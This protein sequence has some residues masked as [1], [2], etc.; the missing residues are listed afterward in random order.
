MANQGFVRDLNLSEVTDGAQL[1]QNLAGGTVDADLRLFAGLSKQKSELFWNSLKN[2]ASIEQSGASLQD[3]IQFQWDTNYTYTDDDYVF[4]VPMNLLQDIATTYIGFA[5]SAPVLNNTVGPEI[6]YDRGENFTPGTYNNVSLTGGNGSGARANIIVDSAGQVESVEITND[7]LVNYQS[8]GIGY[9]AGDILEAP[10]LPGGSGFAL[11]VDTNPWKIALIGNYAWNTDQIS[12]DKLRVQISNTS[13]VLNGLYEVDQVS[14]NNTFA[15]P[16]ESTEKAYDINR[17]LYAQKKILDNIDLYDVSGD[18]T[19]SQWD[20]DVLN[21]F[22]NNPGGVTPAP[23]DNVNYWIAY[24][25]NNQPPAGSSR[26]TGQRVYLYLTGLGDEVFDIDG[27]G[28]KDGLDYDLLT[29]YISNGGLYT[30]LSASTA[31]GASEINAGSLS[32]AISISV[33]VEKNPNYTVPVNV[34]QEYLKPYFIIFKKLSE[35]ENYENVFDNFSAY[36]TKQT[37]S[38]SQT[39]YL[40]T[41]IGQ[42][43]VA[44]GITYRIA[45]K[46][47]IGNNYFVNIVSSGSGFADGSTFG[48][49]PVLTVIESV[50]VFSST[51]EYGVFDSN[52]ANRFFLRTNPRSSIESVK[53]VV[54]FSE[55][56]TLPSYLTNDYSNVPTATLLPD[57][58]FIRDDGLTLSNIQ[59]LEPPEV[60]DRG[61]DLFSSNLG[62]FDYNIDDYADELDTITSNVEESIYLRTTK[63]RIDRALYY[64]KEIVINGYITSFDPDGLNQTE[65]D[66]VLDNSPGIYISNSLSQITNPLA[67]DFAQKTRSYSSDYNPWQSDPA[68]SQLITSSLNVTI[69]DLVWTNEIALDIGT[70][71]GASRYKGGNT[72]LGETLN[73]NFNSTLLAQGK[74]FKLRIEINGEEYYLIMRK[75]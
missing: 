28:V 9:N 38:T 1:L 2:S 52:G 55:N 33:R 68:N 39:G 56:Y 15:T 16:Q 26:S 23:K 49:S 70:Y 65:T 11:R 51:T 25:N 71:Q 54:L 69:N 19:L 17:K 60:Q 67:A 42:V 47:A 4:V 75:P 21:I 12:T 57:L 43:K 64:E 32:H 40:Q 36:G 29:E 6:V 7:G 8:T 18:G 22:Y 10:S 31:L 46:T 14:G 72:A 62:S 35:S 37:C 30:R 24:V 48:S 41:S 44:N 50:S 53:E 27:T 5:P 61:N 66:I 58:V 73:D 3:A 13:N 20:A 59:N 34:E 74:S 63:Y 45:S